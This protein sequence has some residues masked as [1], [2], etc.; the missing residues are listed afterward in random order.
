VL[1]GEF[2]PDL[3]ERLA[4]AD[5]VAD[6]LDEAIAAGLLQAASGA[7]GLLRFS[8]GMV[9]DT[10]YLSI[11]P[12]TRRDLHRRVAAEV[13]RRHAADLGPHLAGLAHHLFE[14]AATD[15]AAQYATGA[16]EHATARLAFE[17]AARLYRLALRALERGDTSDH[18][19]CCDLLL[20]LGEAQARSGD[21]AGARAT[22]LNAAEVARGCASGERL[23]RAAL[24]Y[25]GRW[26]WTAMRGDPHVIPLLEEAIRSLPGHDGDL[27]ARVLARLAAGPL[28]IRGDASRARRFELSA[29][30]VAMARRLGDPAVLAWALDGRKVAIWGPDTMEEHWATIEELRRLADDVGDPEQLVDAHICALIM[31]FER[32]E[33]SAFEAAYATADLA[34]RDLRQPGQ[35]WLVAVM[36]PMHAL[37][38]GRLADAERLIDAAFELGREAA[39]WNARISALLQRFVL[40]GLEGRLRE[41]A[42]EL[43]A[44]VLENPYY[45]VLQAALAALHADLGDTERA[46][47]AFDGLAGD[48]FAAVPLDEEWLLATTLLAS[49]CSFLGDR[50]RAAVLY[51]RLEPYANRVAVGATEVAIGSVSRALGQLAATLSQTDKATHW[52]ERAARENERA[53]A[54]PWAA[55]ARLDH[56]RLLLA[57]SDLAAA[58]PLIRNASAMYR[59]LGMDAWV[60]RCREAMENRDSPR[61]SLAAARR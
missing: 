9:R 40:R 18:Q 1:G 17:E 2:D 41:V 58:E 35:R 30:A 21:D 36:A 38:V 46:R 54:L 43:H 15:E 24:G 14:G 27:R 44:A 5:D 20:A 19:R 34:A 8:H 32:F 12:R 6:A 23:A 22:Y 33:L 37:L 57:G 42:D 7:P 47:A 59:D 16:A 10:L 39:P 3:L 13:E 50:K 48:D 29:E 26:V 28:K 25:G 51:D 31:R 49:A 55:H 53:G 56:G 60:L 4:G 45:P 61:T 52:F 11:P